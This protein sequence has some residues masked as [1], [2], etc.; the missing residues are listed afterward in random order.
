[1]AR[2]RKP[3]TPELLLSTGGSAVL[4]PVS[5]VQEPLLLLAL[6]AE[7]R[8]SARGSEVRVRMASAIE[9]EWLLDLF[10]ERLRDEDR[11]LFNEESERVERLS[12]LAYGALT[13]EERRVAAEPSEAAEAVLAE[14]VLTRRLDSLVGQEVLA[15]LRARLE[16]AAS[17]LPAE[18]WPPTDDGTL[19]GL[20]ARGRRSLAE[21]RQV[22]L[23][24][25]LLATL[26]PRQAALLAR[27]LPERISLPGGR[28]VAV[29]Y[30]SGQPPWI[31]SRL[32]DFFGLQAGP[33]LAGGRVPLVLHLLAPN[34]RA[35]QVTQDLT[36]F[37][38]RHYP[39]LRRELARRYPRHS[40]PEDPLRAVPPPPRGG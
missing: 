28:S 8:R 14:A 33:A 19:A 26:E 29:H 5:V 2:R 25:A 23:G 6:D 35:V 38:S 22:D 37:W 17:A 40:W 18:R 27:E 24:R 39:T 10:P 13:L 4:D 20:L 16:L 3:H 12:R 11:L 9:P 31:A 30:A 34:Q 1:V 36:G 32:Q 7:E 15:S 21:V